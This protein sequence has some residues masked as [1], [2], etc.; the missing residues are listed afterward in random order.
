MSGP[1]DGLRVLE[2]AGLGPVPHAAMVLADLGADVVRVERPGGSRLSADTDL[3]LRHRRRTEADLKSLRDVQ[4]LLE[5]VEQVDVFVEGFR[6]G[7]TERLGIGPSDCL[8]RNPRLIYA[9]VTGWGQ[10]GPMA[11]KAGHDIN[12]IASSGLLAA[13]GRRGS[14][15]VPPLNVV[16]DYGGGSMLAL[17]GVLAALWHARR[18]GEGQVVDVAM[19]DGAVLQSQLFWSMAA[20]G[21]WGDLPGSNLLNGGHPYY[22]TYRCADDEFIAVGAVEPQFYAQLLTGLGLGPADYPQDDAARYPEYR[23]EFARIFATR[24]QAEWA[25]RFMPLDACVTPVR[26]LSQTPLDP[27]VHARQLTVEVD[28]HVHAAPGLAF[29]TRPCADHPRHPRRPSVS[30]TCWRTGCEVSATDLSSSSG[31]PA[32]ADLHRSALMNRRTAVLHA[33]WKS[34]GLILRAQPADDECLSIGD[35]VFQAA[36]LRIPPLR[37]PVEGT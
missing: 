33:A 9:R 36:Y 28:G 2:M 8:A 32:K 18:T 4:M 11:L 24:T 30:T 1:L 25:E 3:L 6:P 27:H 20:Q 10:D 12:Y 34:V 35:D 23:A 37:H 22:D 31:R 19:I 13:I 21:D 29:R 7:V 5:V 17:T 14:P 16:G 26:R 15:P